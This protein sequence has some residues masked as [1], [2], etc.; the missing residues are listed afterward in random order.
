MSSLSSLF[1]EKISKTQAAAALNVNIN[2]NYSPLDSA[3]PAG[4][5]NISSNNL[6]GSPVRSIQSLDIGVSN[7]AAT[8]NSSPLINNNVGPLSQANV[9]SNSIE[10]ASASSLT[11]SISSSITNNNNNNSYNN[12][13]NNNNNNN[14]NS[15]SNSNSNNNNYNND[16]NTVVTEKEM[17]LI[18]NDIETD[19]LL[20]AIE[21]SK[22]FSDSFS[23]TATRRLRNKGLTFPTFNA[24]NDRFQVC[25]I[26]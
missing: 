4:Q 12:N 7:N 16:N 24:R 17:N 15:N 25:E 8:I 26:F 11:S 2:G 18:A 14:S 1:G 6:L 20:N 10:S 21:K 22:G 5:S 9:N 13:N 19:K 23:T 3:A